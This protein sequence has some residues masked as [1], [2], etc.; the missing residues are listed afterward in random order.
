MW[1]HISQDGKAIAAKIR[2]QGG[3][4]TSR[5]DRQYSS[6]ACVLG[7]ASLRAALFILFVVVELLY[8]LKNHEPR[9]LARW[10]FKYFPEAFLWQ[11]ARSVLQI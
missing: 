2:D 6:L 4:L 10:L 11:I 3:L 9:K 5:S 7:S 8:V 1:S